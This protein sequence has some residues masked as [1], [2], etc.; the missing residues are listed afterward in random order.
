MAQQN[1]PAL[2][3]RRSLFGNPDK[4]DAQISP[5]GTQL[6][7]LAPVDGVLNVWVGPVDDPAAARSVTEDRD[8]GIRF[9]TW[10]YTS[11]H[12]LYIQDKGGDENWR[13]YSV[14][15]D[16]GQTKDLTPLEGV[17]VQ[18]QQRSPRF[19]NE[20]LIRLND[21]DPKLHDVYRLNIDTGERT[22]LLRNPEFAEF[23]T[24]DDYQLRFALRLLTDGG[25]EILERTRVESWQSFMRLD[26]E[27]ALTTELVGFDKTGQTLYMR[28]SRRRD[29][30]ALVALN[31][32]TGR[33]TLLAENPRADEGDLLIHPTEKH[34]QAAAFTYERKQ[35]QIIDELIAA[36][37]AYLGTVTGG[38]IDVVSRTLDDKR[39]IVAYTLDNS[40]RRYYYYQR[41][42]QMATF[43]FTD[44]QNLED[45]PLARMHPVVIEARDGLKLVSYYT[46]PVGSDNQ[47]EGRPDRALPL[48]LFVHGGPWGRD[49]WGF[50]PFHQWLANRGYAVLS[51]NFR[52][53]TGFGKAFINA[54]N[55]EWA[56]KM[57]DDLIAAVN[58]A[59][60]SGLADPKRVA[61][62]GGSYGGYAA[63]VGL[64]FTPETFACGV[65][66]VGPSNL[67]TLLES[68]PP[69]WEPTINLLTSRVGDHRTEEGRR[70]L[71]ERSPLSRVD[72]IKRPLLIAQGANDPRVKQAESDQIVRAMQEKGI[73]VTYV[74]YPD[75][76]HGFARPENNLSFSAIAEA[77]LSK[78]LGGRYEPVN[79][80]FKGSSLTVPAG[81]ED[82][83]GLAEALS[84]NRQ[85]F[86][87]DT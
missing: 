51:V 25:L 86:D 10:A 61:I 57:H 27:D 54:A 66:I 81:L 15:L 11:N 29:R 3:P 26:M 71:A 58:W 22:L 4:T 77:F 68:V 7:F 20:L 43:L 9:Y 45:A 21:R 34:I 50:H 16:A 82:V 31:L 12:I 52:S 38:D 65:D 83:P 78:C 69:Y 53:S 76:G 72:Q 63:L 33:Q 48:V 80:D 49:A 85:G 13:L 24:D 87:D 30:V 70:L 18:F 59:V 8:R 23:I 32:E 40:P 79:D 37:L 46:L 44:R 35:W 1:S 56:A 2:I 60:E 55:K 64:T 19:P 67:I 84:N 42:T 14:D 17:Q 74:L 6:S 5:D 41:E 73:P 36:D 28:D 75:E 39:W 62:M 47:V